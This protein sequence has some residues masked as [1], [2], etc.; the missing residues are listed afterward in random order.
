MKVHHLNCGT[1]C[2]AARRLVMGEGGLF[3]RGRLVCHV[4]LIEAPAGLVLVD[5][6]LGL[7]DIRSPRQRLGAFATLTGARLLEEETALRRVEALG[8]D[9]RD[10]RD[11][12]LT[13]GDLDHAGGLS[14]FPW[15]RVHL[16][17]AER[18]VALAPSSAAE[19]ARYRAPQWDHEPQIH[20]YDVDRGEPWRGFDAVRELAGLPPELLLVPLA[21]HSAGHAGVAIDSSAGWLLH[22]GDA[23]F[24]HHEM[25][26]EPTCP[27]ALRILERIDAVDMS[28][29]RANQRRLHQLVH[30]APDVAVFCGH[31]ARELDRMQAAS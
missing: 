14:D 21:G 19:R 16:M 4:L 24:S 13:H 8:F 30:S 20:G 9:P 26:A 18:D 7:E 15:A 23:Y 29:V 25:A 31:D 10:V 27:P 6:G 3:E 5:T 17:R 28:A 12:V 11:V 2:P 22:A 1:L